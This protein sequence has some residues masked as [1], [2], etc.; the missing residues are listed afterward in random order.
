MC[1]QGVVPIV[2]AYVSRLTSIF[3]KRDR[4]LV[5]TRVAHAAWLGRSN[6]AAAPPEPSPQTW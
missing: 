5:R 3:R 1:N 4:F 6:P 2:P